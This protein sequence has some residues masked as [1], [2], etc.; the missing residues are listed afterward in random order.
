SPATTAAAIHTISG[1]TFMTCTSAKQRRKKGARLHGQA[2]LRHTKNRPFDDV[3]RELGCGDGRTEIKA[4]RFVTLPL[5]QE[6]E[7]FL[8]LDAFRDHAKP[9]TARDGDHCADDRTVALVVAHTR[10]EAAVD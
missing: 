5:L 4:L 10:D 2:R 7:L 6:R 3:A 9:Q 1:V 8:C